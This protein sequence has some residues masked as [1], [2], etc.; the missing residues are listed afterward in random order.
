MPYIPQ[1]DRPLLDEKVSALADRIASELAEMKGT[2]HISVL[3]ERSILSIVNTLYRLQI[4]KKGSIPKSTEDALAHA[5][6][7]ISK[8]HDYDCPWLGELNYSLT[9]LIQ[10]V[11]RKMV[12]KGAWKEELRYYIFAQTCGA[13]ERSALQMHKKITNKAHSYIINGMVGALFD[14]KDEYKRRVNTAYEIIQIQKS[15]DCYDGPF[16]TELEEVVDK[17]HKGTGYFFD[18]SRGFRTEE[19]QNQAKSKKIEE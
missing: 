7:E 13:L 11:P 10:L 14:I 8:K 9:R 12:E 4:G 18:K 16:H 5:M 15:G 17:Y 2:A 1:E 6:F 3:Y 19:Q